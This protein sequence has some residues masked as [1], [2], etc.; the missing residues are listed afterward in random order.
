M[1]LKVTLFRHV[2]VYI[3]VAVTIFFYATI[4]KFYEQD[5]RRIKKYKSKIPS[6]LT[7]RLLFYIHIDWFLFK[8]RY[9]LVYLIDNVSDCYLCPILVQQ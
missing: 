6:P 4:K 5:Q 3:C 2:C 9:L 7:Q 1:M 8:Y